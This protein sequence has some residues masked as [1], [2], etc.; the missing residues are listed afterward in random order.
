MGQRLTCFV[1][2]TLSVQVIMLAEKILAELEVPSYILV[3][4]CQPR[5]AKYEYDGRLAPWVRSVRVG[6]ALDI[7]LP[8]EDISWSLC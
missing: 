8:E 5:P 6:S 2:A 7:V 3:E 1:A 4:R